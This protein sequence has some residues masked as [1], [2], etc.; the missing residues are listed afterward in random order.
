MLAEEYYYDKKYNETLKW[1]LTAN[2]IDAQNTKSW[3]WFAKSKVKLN[4]KKDAVRAL[5]A[6]L[7]NNSSKRLSTLLRKIEFGDTD[8]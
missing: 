4:H 6:Y 5:K 7:A 2:D 3:Y 8:D 1:A